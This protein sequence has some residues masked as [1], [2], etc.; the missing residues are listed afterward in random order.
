MPGHSAFS[1]PLPLGRFLRGSPGLG[2]YLFAFVLIV[3]LI[4]LT[5]LSSSSLLLPTEGDMYFY[6]DWA[7]RIA[8]GQLT[9]HFAFYGLPGYAYLLAFFYRIFGYGPFVPG[10]I[11]GCLDAGTAVLVYKIS[12]RAFAD[13]GPENSRRAKVVGALA[14]LGWAFFVPAHAYSIILMPTAWAIFVFWLIVWLIV[15]HDRAP[16]FVECLVYGTLVGLTAAAV[17]TV[18]FL[19]PLLVAATFL[20]TQATMVSRSSFLSRLIAVALIFLGVGLGT[21]P[22][23]A[24]NYV[25]ARDPVFLSGHSGVNFWLGNNPEATGYPHFPGMRAGQAEMLSDSIRLAETAARRPLKRS[26]VSAYWSTKARAYITEDFT[27]WLRLMVRKLKNFWN[28]FEYDDIS[29]L[30]KLRGVGAL[31][32]GLHFGFVAVL[33]L[34]GI[35]LSIRRRPVARWIVAAILLQMAAV[36]SVFVTERYRLAVVPGLLVFAAFGLVTLWENCVAGRATDIA[37]YLGTLVASALLVTL[38]QRDAAPW[39]LYFYNIGIQAFE[40]KNW[41]DAEK[42]LERARAL[43]PSNPEI[44]LALGNV[45]WEQ[46]NLRRAAEFYSAVLRED[47]RHKPAL[48]NL[49]L[50]ASSEHRWEDAI[51]LFREALVIA[52]E[53]AKTHYLLAKALLASGEVM[54]ASR[55]AEIALRLDP[56]QPKYKELSEQIEKQR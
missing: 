49:G 19:L 2:H 31:I 10:F 50:V 36:L 23:W 55:E 30:A 51:R 34:P 12:N 42:H 47:P 8:R 13:V 40:D 27:G 17:A 4:A 11:Q 41:P 56:T 14:A 46:N 52:P 38:P 16:S 45:W 20:K 33:A 5:R 15:K 7:R 29:V 22:C 28:A 44:N 53:D 32:P 3:R 37:L 9:D 43:V 25:V 48:R 54:E 6:D 24:H 26:E 18:L 21:S 39:A 35:C 1:R